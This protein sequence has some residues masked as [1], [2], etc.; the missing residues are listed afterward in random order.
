MVLSE[1][2]L[3]HAGDDYFD[4]EAAI[5]NGHLDYARERLRD[6]LQEKPDA[7]AWYLFSF[8]ANSLQQRIQ[9]LEQALALNPNHQRAQAALERA[10]QAQ[11]TS[12]HATSWIDRLQHLLRR[13]VV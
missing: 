2:T 4:I 8:A 9:F 7:E 13:H 1:Q 10:R 6:V 5:R 11:M 12:A 3:F